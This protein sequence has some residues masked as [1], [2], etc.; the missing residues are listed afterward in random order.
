MTACWAYLALDH[1]T[2]ALVCAHLSPLPET[3]GIRKY[4]RV[5]NEEICWRR[6]YSCPGRT[7]FP[8]RH[9][10]SRWPQF[11]NS[12]V[13]AALPINGDGRAHYIGLIGGV[14]IVFDKI[15]R[16]I[17]AIRLMCRKI[18]HQNQQIARYGQNHYYFCVVF[19]VPPLSVSFVCD[20]ATNILILTPL[21]TKLLGSGVADART[22]RLLQRAS[23]A[24]MRPFVS[25][26]HAK[27][28]W[29]CATEAARA[30]Y[31]IKSL[32]LCYII[33]D[34][35]GIYVLAASKNLHAY[36]TGLIQAVTQCITLLSQ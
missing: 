29:F 23:A 19:T 33:A 18:S 17:P 31:Q 3:V 15:M 36:C 28:D 10:Y 22:G 26:S 14:N 2:A 9:E 11:E 35:N 4:K 5:A 1:I 30:L 25:D 32:N 7:S 20:V 21:K 6:K 27:P 8:A 12:V 13:R 24:V 16:G 34:S